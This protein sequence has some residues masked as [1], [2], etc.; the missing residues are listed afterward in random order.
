[1]TELFWYI[2]FEA[3]KFNNSYYVKEIAILQNNRTQC[4]NYHIRQPEMIKSYS[5]EFEE[6]M[7]RIQIG[8]TYGDYSFDDAVKDIKIKLNGNIAFTSNSEKCT[9][10]KKYISQVTSQTNETP[11][12]TQHCL[13]DICDIRHAYHCARRKVHEMRF[14][15]YNKDNI[16]K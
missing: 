3:V 7:H 9:F 13:S 10:L 8:W 2:D 11:F 4:Y 16:N 5:L 1:M 15:D 6:Q 12:I 14:Y